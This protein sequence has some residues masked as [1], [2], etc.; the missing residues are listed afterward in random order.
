M[1]TL[2]NCRADVVFRFEKFQFSQK[3][4]NLWPFN[5]YLGRLTTEINEIR[6]GLAQVAAV[7]LVPGK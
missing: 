3:D 5:F 7:T 4:S 6:G 1:L 2:V